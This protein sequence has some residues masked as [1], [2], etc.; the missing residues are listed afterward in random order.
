ML[1]MQ[2]LFSCVVHYFCRVYRYSV[3]ARTRIDL[4]RI[5][6]VDRGGAEVVAVRSSADRS[7]TMEKTLREVTRVWIV[8]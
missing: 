6:T 2:H 1:E 3:A 8:V 7:L 5:A 4:R